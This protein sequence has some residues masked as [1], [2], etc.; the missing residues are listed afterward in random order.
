LS[1]DYRAKLYPSYF[2]SSGYERLNAADDA[3]YKRHGRVL[4]QILLPHLP[5]TQEAAILDVAC[6]IGYAVEMLLQAGYTNV[7]GIDLSAE[8]VQVASARGL[9]ITEADVF[10][11][12]EEADDLDV[13]IAFDFIEHLDKN[14]LLRF[15]DLVQTALRPGGRVIVKTPN[16]SC[17]FGAR[18]RYVDLTHELIFTEKSLRAAFATSGLN[19]LLV[20]GERV[21]PSTVRGWVRWLPAKVVRLLWT[22]YLIAELSEEGFDIPTEFNLIGVAERPLSP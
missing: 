3:G 21:R 10:E 18:S 14:E 20:T 4:R 9:P 8:Q 7:H 15:L 17:L 1:H 6:G 5:A 2:S 13:V 16:A 22:G 12:L 19:P 11:H